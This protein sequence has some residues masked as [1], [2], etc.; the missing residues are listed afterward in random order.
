MQRVKQKAGEQQAQRCSKASKEHATKL[1]CEVCWQVYKGYAV[2]G[3]HAVHG[4]HVSC[5]PSDGTQAAL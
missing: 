5:S 1:A 2:K 3:M 4:L